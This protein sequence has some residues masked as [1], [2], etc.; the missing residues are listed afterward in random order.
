LWPRS[1]ISAT[2]EL[3]LLW[4]NGWMHEDATWSGGRPQPRRL[5]VR[6]WPSCPQKKS[7][8]TP[9]NFWPMSTLAKR[10]DGRRRHLVRKK[11]S[12]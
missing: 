7:T 10:L 2:A 4:P 5:C 12:A 8:P 11:T 3:L 9:P 6:R 1:P